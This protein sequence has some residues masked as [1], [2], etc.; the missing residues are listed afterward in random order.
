LGRLPPKAGQ[1][2]EAILYRGGLQRG[3]ISTVLGVTPRHARRIVASLLERGALASETSRAPL[4]LA[5]PAILAGRWMSG[6]FPG[7]SEP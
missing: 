6:L 1:V 7:P 4:L 2:L 3:E 5:F